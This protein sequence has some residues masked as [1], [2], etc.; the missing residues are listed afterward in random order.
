MPFTL[1]TS[2][3]FNFCHKKTKIYVHVS[4]SKNTE[5]R[6]ESK[7]YLRINRRKEMKM[8]FNK[9]IISVRGKHV[10]KHEQN[11]VP[12]GLYKYG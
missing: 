8:F 12:F 3:L 5:V 4:N 9:H 2:M 10:K 7:C 1:S 6:M 11:G